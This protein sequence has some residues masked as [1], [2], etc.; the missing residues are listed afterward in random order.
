[1]IGCE[2]GEDISKDDEHMA[3][4]S[5]DSDSSV[6]DTAGVLDHPH[7]S[8]NVSSNGTGIIITIFIFQ[9][10]QWTETR[11]TGA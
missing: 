4:V 9:L 6:H 1:M 8:E 3:E 10:P 11:G 7:S 5:D 2:S